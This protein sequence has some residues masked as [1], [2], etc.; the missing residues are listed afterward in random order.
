M[1]RDGTTLGCG[2]EPDDIAAL[3]AMLCGDLLDEPDLLVRYTALTRE[4]ARLQALVSYVK[5]ERGKLVAK[6]VDQQRKAAADAGTPIGVVE[7]RARVA[8]VTGLGTHQRVEQLAQSSSG[9]N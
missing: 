3:Y 9:G 8:D 1:M 5:T 4:Q 2:T 6:L 7:A